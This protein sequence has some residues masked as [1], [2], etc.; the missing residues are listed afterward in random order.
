MAAIVVG[1]LSVRSSVENPVAQRQS[2]EGKGMQSKLSDLKRK[3]TTS[4]YR[5]L[6]LLAEASGIKTSSG[7]SFLNVRGILD[8]QDEIAVLRSI[9]SNLSSLDIND[10]NLQFFII[11]RGLNPPAYFPVKD[12]LLKFLEEVVSAGKR[13]LEKGQT[14]SESLDQNSPVQ[15]RLAGQEM[16]FVLR[17]SQLLYQRTGGSLRQVASGQTQE[18][19]IDSLNMLISVSLVNGQVVITNNSSVPLSVESVQKREVVEVAT[20]DIGAD[21]SNKG[22]AVILAR[23]KELMSEL[24]SQEAFPDLKDM[25]NSGVAQRERQL[26]R[27]FFSKLAGDSVAYVE[28]ELTGILSRDANITRG[29]EIVQLLFDGRLDEL[30]TLNPYERKRLYEAIFLNA[31]IWKTSTG[32]M[33][34]LVNVLSLS[35]G[36][37]EKY[38]GITGEL[39]VD[40][41]FGEDDKSFGYKAVRQI[42]SARGYPMSTAEREQAIKKYLGCGGISIPYRRTNGVVGSKIVINLGI[43]GFGKVMSTIFH[44]MGHNVLQGL[45]RHGS[46]SKDRMFVYEGVAEDFSIFSLRE[47]ARHY[48]N[49]PA[50]LTLVTRRQARVMKEKIGLNE[51]RFG[52][53]F[54]EQM[55]NRVGM[56]VFHWQVVSQLVRIIQGDTSIRRLSEAVFDAAQK[57]DTTGGIDLNASRLDL[58]VENNGKELNFN[59]DSSMAQQLQNATGF[60]PVVVNIHPLGNLSQYLEVRPEP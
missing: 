14:F 51:S 11:Q 9:A 59:F 17:G 58:Q 57:P 18:Y 53:V 42:E 50:F 28:R 37:K 1:T 27:G 24:A 22:K 33:E 6:K 29:N 39:E 5:M 25:R 34:T 21:V 23:E 44:E 32:Q 16:T 7:D 49:H 2:P 52:Y 41:I 35:G 36:L 12:L 15:I 60:T 10:D 4:Y 26:L 20:K 48:D 56:A 43:D 38:F 8:Q 45:S 46:F 3:D 40:I 55:R 19:A 47:L 31:R 30:N 13:N 54:M